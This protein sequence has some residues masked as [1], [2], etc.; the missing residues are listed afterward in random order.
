MKAG[1]ER[2]RELLFPHQV[3]SPHL[4]EAGKD[5]LHVWAA[6][7]ALMATV[8]ERQNSPPS[9]STQELA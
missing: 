5:G 3:C 6:L 2:S 7:N 4:Q 1:N 8:L 9:G